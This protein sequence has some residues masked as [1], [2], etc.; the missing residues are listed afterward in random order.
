MSSTGTTTW[1]SSSFACRRRRARIGRPPPD[2]APDLLDRPLRRREPDPLQR[3]VVQ[4]ARA[5]RRESARCAPRFV[6]AT[7]WTSSRIS[8]STVPQDLA[9]LRGEEQEE[10]LGRRDQ[11]VRRVAQHRRA[12]LLR[13][14]AGPHADAE[15]RLEARERPAQVAL[16]VVVQRLERRHVEQP[17]PLPRRLVQPVDPVQERRERLARAGR[18]LDEDVA[19]RSRSPASPAPAAASGR[20]MRSNHPRV[21]G[22]R[23]ERVHANKR[24]P[25]AS[26]RM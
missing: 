24:T 7:A 16:D 15:L 6:P 1:R 10:R 26:P 21:A 3:P 19:R 8:V 2:E 12:L 4:R 23:S 13:R 22:G 5:A 9:R 17:E 14:V 11:D 20:R 25:P 18:R